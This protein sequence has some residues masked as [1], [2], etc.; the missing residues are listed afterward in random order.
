LAQAQAFRDFFRH[1]IPD[2]VVGALTNLC[3]DGIACVVP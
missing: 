1:I 2:T 3:G